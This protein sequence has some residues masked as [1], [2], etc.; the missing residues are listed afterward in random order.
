MRT[1]LIALLLLT[2]LVVSAADEE[3]P[4]V[5]GLGINQIMVQAH[6][7]PMNRGTKNNLDNKLLDGKATE[8]EKKRLIDLYA[9]LG[10]RQ[11]PMG[12]GESWAKR[13]A[14]LLAATKALAD[15]EDKAAERFLKA[16]DCKGCHAAH[17][18]RF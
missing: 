2:P 4:A 11:P 7:K 13:T 9:E 5:G 6:L 18:K 12:D 16:R 8:D 14:E 17:R 10:K 3:P 1:R 15:G